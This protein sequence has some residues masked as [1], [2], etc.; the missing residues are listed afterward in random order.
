MYISERYAARH[1]FD[2]L[3]KTLLQIL[4]AS[5]QFVKDLKQNR[6]VFTNSPLHGIVSANK[7][8]RTW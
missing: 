8:L 1:L 4:V 2:F 7:H 6:T 3:L 5:D